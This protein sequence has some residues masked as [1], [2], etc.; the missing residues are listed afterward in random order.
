[1]HL[2]FTFA[3]GEA[4]LYQTGYPLHGFP[5]SFQGK[6]KGGKSKKGKTD[7]SP[8][9]ELKPNSLL[10]A[11][12]R[13]D[14]SVYV[15]QPDMEPRISL[16]SSICSRIDDPRSLL[17]STSWNIVSNGEG[18]TCNRETLS[19][20]PLLSTL[21]SLSLDEG[22]TCSNSEL[23]SALENLG[24]NADDLE[25]LLLDER[26]IQVELDPT[27]I[28]SLNDLLT[29]N[30][31]LSY[32]QDSLQTEEQTVS[33][34]SHPTPP[35]PAATRQPIIQLSL[36]MQ[37]HISATE[38]LRTQ[39]GQIQSAPRPGSV[40]W[41]DQEPPSSRNTQLNGEHPESQWQLLTDSTALS[42]FQNQLTSD[43]SY[44]PIQHTT[45]SVNL[46]APGYS[47]S[48]H[49][50]GSLLNGQ[51][52]PDLCYH[53]SVVPPSSLTHGPPQSSASELEQLLA[54]PPPPPQDS[55]M[56]LNY[57]LLSS[58]VDNKV[59][60]TFICQDF[61]SDSFTFLPSL[62]YFNVYNVGPSCM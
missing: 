26:M 25:L 51:T 59:R 31:I 13:Q 5:D 46:Q 28:P 38:L 22:E 32:V 43:G 1:M 57:N 17:S 44:L 24:L 62:M 20:D 2:P 45:T 8:S 3:T 6:A 55:L 9:D 36:Q 48:L 16:H 49:S 35:A 30:E 21:D 29:N 7:K 39:P 37:Q 42:G 61:T 53:Q 4:L 58:T 40:S 60:N 33:Q 19:F 34:Q 41:V 11:L 27:H 47:D 12:M 52:A 23:F 50:D 14:E 15:S 54:L 18:E 56:P 10:G